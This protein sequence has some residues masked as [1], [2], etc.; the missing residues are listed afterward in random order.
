MQHRHHC[1]GRIRDLMRLCQAHEK[2][3]TCCHRQHNTTDTPDTAGASCLKTDFGQVPAQYPRGSRHKNGRV[4]APVHQSH[5]LVYQFHYKRGIVT[6][7]AP[8]P[9]LQAGNNAQDNRARI[10]TLYSTELR[11]M[12]STNVSTSQNSRG[13]SGFRRQTRSIVMLAIRVVIH[14]TATTATPALA[15]QTSR[16]DVDWFWNERETEQK[17][18]GKPGRPWCQKHCCCKR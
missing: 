11:K 12:P 3:T 4:S 2:E 17:S 13:R 9:L 5:P 10:D 14:M 15:N 1:T 8:K 18:F 6:K 7:N 16:S